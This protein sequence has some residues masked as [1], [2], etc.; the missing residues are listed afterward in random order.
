[1]DELSNE[2]MDVVINKWLIRLINEQ[3]NNS[4]SEY[5]SEWVDG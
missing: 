3:K 2:W 4:M 5:M 1:M